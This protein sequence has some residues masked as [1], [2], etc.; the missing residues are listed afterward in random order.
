MGFFKSRGLFVKSTLMGGTK[1]K[2]FFLGGGG[3]FI[4]LNQ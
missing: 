3:G 1:I 2:I 4:L